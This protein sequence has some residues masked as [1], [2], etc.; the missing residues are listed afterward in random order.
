MHFLHFM[1]HEA[2]LGSIVIGEFDKR[3]VV[4]WDEPEAAYY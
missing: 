4:W 2:I 3:S 1:I